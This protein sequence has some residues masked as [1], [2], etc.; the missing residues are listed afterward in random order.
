MSVGDGQTLSLM[1]FATANDHSESR[2]ALRAGS[3]ALNGTT[4]GR[5]AELRRK[6][7]S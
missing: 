3:D 7:E 2:L 1:T 4:T 6:N 5:H